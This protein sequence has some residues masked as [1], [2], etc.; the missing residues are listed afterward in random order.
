MCLHETQKVNVQEIP[1][2]VE[3]FHPINGMGIQKVFL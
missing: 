3:T 2:S 1:E